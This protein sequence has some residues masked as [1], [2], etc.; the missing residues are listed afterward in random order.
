LL[1]LGFLDVLVL[2]LALV[3]PCFLGHV[4]LLSAANVGRSTLQARRKEPEPATEE[5]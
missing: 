5:I 3:A 1:L 2:A 4:A